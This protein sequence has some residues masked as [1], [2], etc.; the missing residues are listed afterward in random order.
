MNGNNAITDERVSTLYCS[1][2]LFVREK[3]SGNFDT[4][5]YLPQCTT[6]AISVTYFEIHVTIILRTRAEQMHDGPERKK[7]HEKTVFF[8]S[9][10]RNPDLTAA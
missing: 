8:F 4:I 1:Y 5:S 9:F 3:F 2:I 10:S 7:S 6:M